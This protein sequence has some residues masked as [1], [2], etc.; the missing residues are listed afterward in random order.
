MGDFRLLVTA[1]SFAK[2]SPEPVERLRANSIEIVKSSIP[3]PLDEDGMLR[4]LAEAGHIDALM[5]GNDAVTEKV[6]DGLGAVKVISRYGVGI[7][8]IDIPA[9]TRRGIVVTNTPGANDQSVADLAT[10]LIMACARSIPQHV[11]S[12]QAGS[13]E[14]KIG[15]ELGGKILGIIGLGRIG[16][17]LAKRAAAFGM[18]VMAFDKFWNEAFAAENGVEWASIETILRMSDFVS[19]HVP[20]TPETENLINADTIAMMKDGACLINTARGELVDEGA[21]ANAVRSGKLR[22]AAADVTRHEPPTGSPLLGV[23]GILITP[24]IGANTVEAS[25]LMSSIAADNV[26]AVLAGK[27][28]PN[29]VN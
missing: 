14:R 24:H 18:R 10:G 21:L 13:W 8:N 29:Q 5:V 22:A 23:D 19:L 25:K 17:G 28:C 16:K 1:R 2:H 27:E 11:N 15:I 26:I 3:G 20:A 9:A 12:V 4:A 7:D 6:I